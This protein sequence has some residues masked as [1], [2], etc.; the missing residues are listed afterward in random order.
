MEEKKEFP[1]SEEVKDGK[2]KDFKGKRRNFKG[3][4]DFKG[5]GCNQRPGN[6]FSFWN[7]YPE[8]MKI[9]T[10]FPWMHIQ[11]T[12]LK[13]N[14]VYAQLPNVAVQHYHP[15]PGVQGNAT[16]PLNLAFRQMYLDMHRKYRG[17][18]TYQASDIAITMLCIESALQ[19][20]V[21]AERVYGIL[22]SYPIK[23]RIQPDGLLLA[24]GYT[25]TF[26]NSVKANMA[27]FRYGI[28]RLISLARRL[29]LPA[30]MKFFANHTSLNAFVYKDSQ[31]DRAALLVFVS[32]SFFEYKTTGQTGCIN[33]AGTAYLQKFNRGSFSSFSGLLADIETT[34]DVLLYD[35]DIIKITSDFIACYGD[36]AM[37]V[38][39][40]LPEDYAINPAYDQAIISKWHN[41]EAPYYTNGDLGY[42]AIS[43]ST[44]QL[45]AATFCF[46]VYQE[47]D[48]IYSL[49]T[50]VLNTGG[51]PSW[52]A[53]TDAS[54]RSALM[55]SATPSPSWSIGNTPHVADTWMPEPDEATI[56]EAMLW[57]INAHTET[58][59]AK[60]CVLYDSICTELFSKCD[61]C[62]VVNASVAY[63]KS[64]G[65][66]NYS[67]SNGLD[68]GISHFDWHPL[69]LLWSANQISDIKGDVD[70]VTVVDS[71]TVDKIH[72]AALLSAFKVQSSGRSTAE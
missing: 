4:R 34:L 56:C 30:G 45:T 5:K 37:Q 64:Y 17:V 16:S 42:V 11:G 33:S 51:T 14:N 68:A 58:H 50:T 44:T 6:D 3:K 2:R 18:G 66:F 72:D 46:A 69:I 54:N 70:N 57:K 22:N 47:N 1:T 71:A 48:I 62:T 41:A 24:M 52:V 65:T 12:Y 36:G 55:M 67:S 29:P 10:R 35:S 40:D 63:T 20:I 53:F 23:T 8:L 21:E 28:N 60:S 13:G 31:D 32:D 9:A 7:E 27:D 39:T 43:A 26:I 25:S 38:L 49:P 61:V 59:S 15:I 19:K